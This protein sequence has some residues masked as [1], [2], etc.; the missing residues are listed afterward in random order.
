VLV[1]RAVIRPSGR[2]REWADFTASAGLSSC[3]AILSC[4]ARG[5]NLNPAVG[6]DDRANS[7]AYSG[8]DVRM[9][10]HQSMNRIILF[11]PWIPV[12]LLFLG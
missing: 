1:D 12:Q 9:N 6:L 3:Q 4:V 10:S 2:P 7:F 5:L 8:L 11:I